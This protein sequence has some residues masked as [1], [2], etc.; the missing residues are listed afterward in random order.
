MEVN[1]QIKTKNKQAFSE[2]GTS[3]DLAQ[4]KYVEEQEKIC[5]S[6]NLDHIMNVLKPPYCRLPFHLRS[7]AFSTGVRLNG[8]DQFLPFETLSHHSLAE[9]LAHI[10]QLCSM[11]NL[12]YKCKC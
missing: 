12:F 6:K 3:S 1:L 8:K 9:N 10:R 11:K 2:K 7:T 5:T 4:M